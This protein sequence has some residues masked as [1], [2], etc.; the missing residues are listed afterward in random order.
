[1]SSDEN[2][3]PVINQEAADIKI[4][5]FIIVKYNDTYYPGQVRQIS[6]DE[7]YIS[8]MTRIGKN[9]FTWPKPEDVCWYRLC[10]IADVIAEPI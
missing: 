5:H 6:D 7:L 2:L 3:P 9:K 4:G 1:M 10:D 8:C